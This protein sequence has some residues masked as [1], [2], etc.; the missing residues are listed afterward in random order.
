MR[1]RRLSLTLAGL[2]LAIGLAQT[3][4]TND[5]IIKMAK[6]G[7]GEEVILSTMNAQPGMY[8]TSTDDL[9]ALKRAGVSDKVITAIVSKMAGG[10]GA[11][12]APPRAPAAMTSAPGPVNEVGVYYKKGDSWTDLPP[13]VVNFKTGGVLK[14]IGTAGIVKGGRQWARQRTPRPDL[15]QV[16]G[17]PACVHRRGCCHYGIPAFAIA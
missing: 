5:A 11:A 16:A 12:A 1:I 2:L 14:T 7:L 10:G 9:I 15:G 17:W 3:G 6:A 4:L 8:T 13:E